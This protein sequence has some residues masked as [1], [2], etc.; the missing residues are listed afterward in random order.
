MTIKKG[1]AVIDSSGSVTHKFRDD[2]EVVLGKTAAQIDLKGAIYLGENANGDRIDNIPGIASSDLTEVTYDIAVYTQ[3]AAKI[4]ASD[5]MTA[6][7]DYN[8]GTGLIADRKNQQFDTLTGYTNAY[9]NSFASG[10]KGVIDADT[11]AGTAFALAHT[12]DKTAKTTAISTNWHIPNAARIL[13]EDTA[14]GVA[15]TAQVGLNTT[16][17]TNVDAF[18]ALNAAA[19][20]IDTY[21]EIVDFITTKDTANDA[22][23]AST[24]QTLNADLGLAADAR[25][26]GDNA[27]MA[28][29]VAEVATR[30]AQELVLEANISTLT[31]AREDDYIQ[32][33][34]D[35]NT[36]IGQVTASMASGDNTVSG[37]VAAAALARTNAD[38]AL[39]NSISTIESQL[40]SQSGSLESDLATEVA[41][42][43]TAFGTL[44]TSIS[45]MDSTQVSLKAALEAD[46]AERSSIRISNMNTLT[47]SLD[48]DIVDFNAHVSSSHS[49][50][51]AQLSTAISARVSADT[52]V[53]DLVA[54]EKAD[55]VTDHDSLSGSIESEVNARTVAHNSLRLLVSTM[56]DDLDAIINTPVNLDEFS[57]IVTYITDEMGVS[58]S[59]NRVAL[60]NSISTMNSLI[61]DEE[62]AADLADGVLT[63]NLNSEL[64]SMNSALTSM[65]TRQGTYV[66]TTIPAHAAAVAADLVADK[67]AYVQLDAN[68]RVSLLGD[69]TAEEAAASTADSLIQ[70]AIDA[71][72]TARS[73]AISAEAAARLAADTALSSSI[74]ALLQTGF[75]G[76]DVNVTGDATLGSLV[77]APSA[78][79]KIGT[80]TSIPTGYETGDQSSRNGM[81]FYLDMA[82]FAASGPFTANKKWYFCEN[83]VWH[84]SPFYKE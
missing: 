49:T 55:M 9:P 59:D 3:N 41:D 79:T 6:Q 19:N 82:T 48:A 4:P 73:N 5:H 65:T 35:L 39:E 84:M 31:S 34:A 72:A 15:N 12:N 60:E 33:T 64:S 20:T 75:T 17:Q 28:D 66:G 25:I 53:T 36:M 45:T 80:L 14:R 77:L 10:S 57:E 44:S 63:S 46:L 29:L 2:G 1:L 16:A 78:K 69:I 68:R 38:G 61:A 71:E 83:G 58:G 52:S 23:L 7:Y 11:A 24:F 43:G 27:V 50:H 51:S 70:D 47:A 42:R 32:L 26:A 30:D 74:D 37:S 18:M 8:P 62:D 56:S 22:A 81:M 21:T 40:N 67:A 54:S 76:Q 13:A